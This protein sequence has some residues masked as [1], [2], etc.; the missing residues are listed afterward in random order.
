MGPRSAVK[1]SPGRT[2]ARWCSSCRRLTVHSPGEGNGHGRSCV[3]PRVIRV[4]TLF[5]VKHGE[6][7]PFQ[8]SSVSDVGSIL[9]LV[10]DSQRCAARTVQGALL[11]RGVMPGGAPPTYDSGSPQSEWSHCFT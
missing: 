7:G 10:T 9:E 11:D 8:L 3:E 4:V 1:A 6:A 5:H 2:S